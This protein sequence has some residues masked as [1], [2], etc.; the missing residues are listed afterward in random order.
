[1][2]WRWVIRG[3]AVALV[4]LCVAAWAGS[5]WR[6]VE[7][8]YQG[9]L[10]NRVEFLQGRLAVV[11]ENEHAPYSS[12]WHYSFG[13]AYDPGHWT[14]SDEESAY[15][16]FGFS[17]GHDNEDWPRNFIVRW[18]TV[19]LW[20]PSLLSALLLWLV[21]RKT[22]AKYNGKGFPVEVAGGGKKVVGE[23]KR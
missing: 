3:L 16:I 7:I 2:V 9:K 22:R 12:A 1:M 6:D 10:W 23:V 19:P 13:D 11:Q 20:L 8:E 15:H 17:F 14:R 5:F 4:T 18:V 21:W